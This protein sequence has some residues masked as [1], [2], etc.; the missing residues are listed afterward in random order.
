LARG[1]WRFDIG[2]RVE[3]R[4]ARWCRKWAAP[5]ISSCNVRQVRRSTSIVN[6]A[7]N[8]AREERLALTRVSS[9]LLDSW[10]SGKGDAMRG[11]RRRREKG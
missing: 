10:P 1:F 4:V 5:I 2:W 7:E 9:S 11:Q 6:Q 8:R 3:G